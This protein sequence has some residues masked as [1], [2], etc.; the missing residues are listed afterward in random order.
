MLDM[1]FHAAFN[2]E[3]TEDSRSNRKVDACKP[4]GKVAHA[5]LADRRHDSGTGT[6]ALTTLKVYSAW[7]SI[8]LT[9]TRY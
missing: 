3:E 8:S 7:Q 1:G 4:D 2:H 5:L 9:V 6:Y